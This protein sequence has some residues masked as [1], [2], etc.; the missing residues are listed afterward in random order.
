MEYNL[1]SLHSGDRMRV[2]V[3]SSAPFCYISSDSLKTYKCNKYRSDSD[4]RSDNAARFRNV[5]ETRDAD[6]NSD[7]KIEF[8]LFWLKKKEVRK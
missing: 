6:H 5:S 2:D 1:V 3:V 8:H 4:D 7:R